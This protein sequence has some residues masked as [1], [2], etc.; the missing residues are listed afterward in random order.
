M[1]AYIRT[2]ERAAKIFV[3]S[4]VNV[5]TIVRAVIGTVIAVFVL[6]FGLIML[7]CFVLK[8][9]ENGWVC[10]KSVRKFKCFLKRPRSLEKS[11]AA[12]REK[13]TKAQMQG[14]VHF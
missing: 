7:F 1:V 2:A 3:D 14:A 9:R 12:K 8:K 5:A 13:E 4:A 11:Q 6:I 10:R